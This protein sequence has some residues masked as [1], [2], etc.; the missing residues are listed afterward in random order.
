VREENEAAVNLY[1]SL[2][3]REYTRRTTWH[4][5]FNI[6]PAS[7]TNAGIY[8]QGRRKDDWPQQE[9][10]LA[11][12]YPP[13]VAWHFPLHLNAFR[14]DLV[15]FFYKIFTGGGL[16]HWAAH[17][18]GHLEGVV[19]WRSS[20]SYYNHLWLAIPPEH[21]PAVIETLLLYARQN[22]LSTR[23]VAL[24]FPAR[25]AEQA[26]LAAGFSIHQTLIWMTTPT[27]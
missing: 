25:L 26:I 20:P 3:F 4:A 9:T 14:S 22:V 2:G 7:Y 16:K 12:L 5:P 10:W 18:N 11:H 23:P 6:G 19:S 13:E 17:K 21:D 27:S 8:I 24:D 1:L 15:G